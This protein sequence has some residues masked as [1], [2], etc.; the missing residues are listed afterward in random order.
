MFTTVP[1]PR[2]HCQVNRRPG[3]RSP[4]RYHRRTSRDLQ[5]STASFL[6][7]R[8]QLP[9]PMPTMC[10]FVYRNHQQRLIIAPQSNKSNFVLS[11]CMGQSRSTLINRPGVIRDVLGQAGGT[12][13]RGRFSLPESPVGIHCIYPL[14]HVSLLRLVLRHIFAFDL[15]EHMRPVRQPDQQIGPV[16][17]MMP[18]KM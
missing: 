16:L 17:A 8:Y 10:L 18:S 4:S 11:T 2:V 9:E 15:K 5:S 1:P 12:T 13:A 3:V 6:A 14:H 7:H